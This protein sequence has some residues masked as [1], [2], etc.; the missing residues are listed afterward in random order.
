MGDIKDNENVISSEIKFM[1]ILREFQEILI[2]SRKQSTT[3]PASL[4][5]PKIMSFDKTHL[6]LIGIVY[7]HRHTDP[8]YVREN[9]E[10]NSVFRY[11][12]PCHCRKSA[13]FH[14]LFF[15][16]NE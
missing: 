4:L 11:Y 2:A 1:K 13:Q 8:I 9:V 6:Q 12:R 15:H 10:F 5:T 16:M 3:S 7:H 14:E